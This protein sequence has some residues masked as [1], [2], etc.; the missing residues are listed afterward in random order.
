VGDFN[1]RGKS[2]SHKSFRELGVAILVSC[3]AMK[4]SKTKS[5]EW[6]LKERVFLGFAGALVMGLGFVALL[7]GKLHYQNYWHAPVFA[8]FSVFVGAVLLF[9]AIK[10]GRF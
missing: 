7:E 9:A 4:G 3:C 8:S 6:T 2:S 10:G 5:R 1:V